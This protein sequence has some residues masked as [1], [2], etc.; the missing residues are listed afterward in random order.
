MYVPRHNAVLDEAHLLEVMRSHPFAQLVSSGS[1]AGLAAT[2]LPVVVRDK[3]TLQLHLARANPQWRDLVAGAEA[4][5]LFS[6][7]HAYVS[8]AWYRVER[9]TVPTWNYVAVHAYGTFRE[10]T[11]ADLRAHLDELVVLNERANGTDWKLSDTP[12]RIVAGL[13]K[14]VVGFEVKVTRL[15]ARMKMSQN[16]ETEDRRGAIEGL[17]ATKHPEAIAT[18]AW[19]R[20]ILG[21]SD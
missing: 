1:H 7:P 21:E 13:E 11:G 6:G 18:A 12:E 15:D 8:P 5:L 9:E 2:H 19:M 3:D 17:E 20:R 10:L 14:G 4:M 16:Y